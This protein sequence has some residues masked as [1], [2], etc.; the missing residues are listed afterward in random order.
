MKNL[1]GT[2]FE[3][4][5]AEAVVGTVIAARAGLATK[6]DLDVLRTEW[7]ADLN[8]MRAEVRADMRELKLELIKWLGGTTIAMGGIAVAALSLILG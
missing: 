3:E 1:V 7:R 6:A 5:Q 2:G 8:L 4:P